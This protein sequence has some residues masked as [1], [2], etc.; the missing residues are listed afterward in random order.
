MVGK[1]GELL[2]T[3]PARAFLRSDKPAGGRIPLVHGSNE[4]P[5]ADKTCGKVDGQLLGIH[6]NDNGCI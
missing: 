3:G 4:E 2:M 5:Y 6:C 1:S